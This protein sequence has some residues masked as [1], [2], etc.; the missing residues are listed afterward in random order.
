MC[1]IRGSQVTWVN[2]FEL[3]V[4]M[5][6]DPVFGAVIM[7][8]MG[9]TAAEIFRD[10]ALALQLGVTPYE[11]FLEGVGAADDP[12]S[13]GRQMPSHWGH[14]DLRIMSTSSPTGTQFLQAVGTAEAAW[15]ATRLPELQEHAGAHDFAV[16]LSDDHLKGRLWRVASLTDRL[17]PDA[18][19]TPRQRLCRQFVGHLP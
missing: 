2:Q 11:M 13:G 4:G 16:R 17:K 9:G 7:V 6:K 12:A 18:L 19:C 14:R 10:R 5:K 1:C 15:R 3:I 8:G